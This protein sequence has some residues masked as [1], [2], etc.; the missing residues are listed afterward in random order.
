MMLRAALVPLPVH[1]RRP[2]VEHLHPIRADVTHPALGILGEHK[3]QRDEAAPV[4]RPA[5]QDRQLVER[6]VAAHDLLARRV[7]H[8]LR[9]QIAQSVD[10]RCELER[11]EEALGRRRRHQLIDL[12]GEVVELRHAERET[13][14]LE[15]AEH[16][17]GDGHAEAG[18]LL[19]Q[20]G[21]SS[22]RRLA[23]PIGDGGDLEI[24]AD[25]LG[26]AHKEFAFVEVFQ[27]FV[28]I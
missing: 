20:Q 6:S 27:E 22:A 11:V 17:A 3:R 4:L 16:V 18:R 25:R 2:G 7:L 1:A 10:E 24:G 15:R 5:F 13:H 19:E 21:R 26:D 23:R 8:G 12:T 14:P 28:E 9:H